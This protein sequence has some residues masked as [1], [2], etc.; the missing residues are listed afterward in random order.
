MRTMLRSGLLSLTALIILGLVPHT[1]LAATINVPADQPTIQ[2]AINIASNGDTVLVAPGTYYENI[3]FMGKAITVTSSG[4][5]SVTTINGNAAGSVVTFNSNEGTNSLLSGF[6]ITNGIGSNNANGGGISISLASPTIKGNVITMNSAGGGEAGGIYAS[7]SSALIQNNVISKNQAAGRYS[8]G[9][10]MEGSGSVQLIGN[11]IS[12]NVGNEGGGVGVNPG[13]TPTIENNTISGNTAPTIINGPVPAGGGIFIY[14]YALVVQ[15]LITG[16]SANYGGGVYIEGFSTNYTTPVLVNNTIANN[17]WGAVYVYEN[18][19]GYGQSQLINNLIVAS[20]GQPA[21]ICDGG[22]GGLQDGVPPS[23]QSSDAFSSSGNGFVGNCAGMEGTNGN[24]SADPLFL[25][26]AA[27]FHVQSG[28]PVIDAGVNAAPNLPTTDLDGNPRIV[29]GVVDMG[30]FEFFPASD[31]ISPASLTFGS[32]QIGSSSAAQTVT[33]TNTGGTKLLLAISADANF[34][35]TNNCGT[36]C[37]HSIPNW[38]HR[39]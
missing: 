21:L 27:N 7:D 38:R 28:S 39:S 34:A 29:N 26:P 17:N 3:N 8:G 19:S 18:P 30:A 22:D 11:Q 37:R 25:D 16:N 31:S 5:P 4:G 9:V 20:P 12:S 33:I 13:V 24:I 15:N 32:Q 23:V 2:A 10:L 14:G 1:A 6:T 36:T 35:E